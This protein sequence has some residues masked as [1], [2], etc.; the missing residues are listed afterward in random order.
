MRRIL[1]LALLVGMI[2]TV[3]GCQSAPQQGGGPAGGP[4]LAPPH[5]SGGYAPG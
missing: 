4:Y 1:W 2:G 5:V 3:V